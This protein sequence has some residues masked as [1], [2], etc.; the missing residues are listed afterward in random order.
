MEKATFNSLPTELHIQIL[1]FLDVDPPSYAKFTNRPTPHILDSDRP[2]KNASEVNKKW[3]SVAIPFLFR[4]TIWKI[5]PK[6]LNSLRQCR[7][8]SEIDILR[9]LADH[10]ICDHVDSIVLFVEPPDDEDDEVDLM[11]TEPAYFQNCEALWETLFST[12]DPLRFSIIARPARLGPLLSI[13]V[14]FSN[15]W[16]Y[17]SYEHILSLSRTT[18]FITPQPHRPAGDSPISIHS[19]LFTIR[20]WTA[21]LLNEGCNMGPYRT[22]EHHRKTPPSILPALVGS[23]QSLHT[24]DGGLFGQPALLPPSVQDFSYIAEFPVY[25]HF[26]KVVRNLPRLHRL[27]IQLVPKPHI[28]K[29]EFEMRHIDTR[30]LWMERNACYAT[31][32]THIFSWSPGSNWKHLHIFESGDTADRVRH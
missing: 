16:C 3:R 21:A 31:L 9:F 25:N 13:P 28:L 15:Y 8:P 24:G 23:T 30:D 19:K 4:H 7:N 27:Y 5:Q 22:Y 29:D 18:R 17:G 26:T 20:P 1:S 10:D 6:D 14:D 11:S 12:I 2:L 32:M